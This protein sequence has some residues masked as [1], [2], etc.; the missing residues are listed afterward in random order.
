MEQELHY[1]VFQESLSDIVII[2]DFK[3]DN[4]MYVTFSL[5]KLTVC[6]IEGRRSIHGDRLGAV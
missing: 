2:I 3:N 1:S 5:P 4:F 6:Y